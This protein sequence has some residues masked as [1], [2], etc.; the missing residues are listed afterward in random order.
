M[1]GFERI[2]ARVG[3][4]ALRSYCSSAIEDE[5]RHLQARMQT[6]L[7]S[8][9]QALK[10][11]QAVAKLDVPLSRENAAT[12]AEIK[13]K[14]AAF[15]ADLK[16]FVDEQRQLQAQA[17]PAAADDASEPAQDKRKQ[18]EQQSRERVAKLLA[19]IQHRITRKRSDAWIDK[20][21]ADVETVA[22]IISDDA[23]AGPDKALRNELV[24]VLDHLISAVL[25]SPLTN[26]STL[27]KMDKVLKKLA[28][29]HADID[30]YI[31][32]SSG[33]L[34]KK[35]AAYASQ[36]GVEVEE[37]RVKRQRVETTPDSDFLVK[38]ERTAAAVAAAEAAGSDATYEVFVS[39][40]PWG[41]TKEA[42]VASYFG[43]AGAVVSVQMPT[44]PDGS[45]VG[46]AV[47]R[48]AAL[49]GMTLALR[50]DGYPFNGKNIRVVV[51]KSK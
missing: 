8:V 43:I 19:K 27:E 20:N 44:M 49:E 50:M 4:D 24:L 28:G 13:R 29:V 3:G 38:V 37:P 34:T 51:H 17:P 12:C 1:S 31:R 39:D 47:V 33:L 26:Q 7:E 10:V 6:C 32:T 30:E 2:L 23:F 9:E 22:G 36:N 41:T 16:G 11:Q 45:T 42:D 48:F 40:L 35:R 25:L 14:Y 18:S 46:V 21:F 5:L 15:S